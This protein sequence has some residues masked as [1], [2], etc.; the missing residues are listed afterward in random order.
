MIQ[1]Q[2]RFFFPPTL[3]HGTGTLFFALIF[4]P[5]LLLH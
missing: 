1:F 5:L 2:Q 3:S 4:T